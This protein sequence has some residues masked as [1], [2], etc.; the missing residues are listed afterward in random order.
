MKNYKL[1]VS[2][3]IFLSLLVSC[4]HGVVITV[5]VVDSQNKGFQCVKQD[6]KDGYFLPFEKGSD[7]LCASPSDTEDFMKAC[8]QHNVINITLCSING[9]S[10]L[11]KGPGTMDM[12]YP[13]SQLAGDNFVCLNP[14]DRKRVIE[15]CTL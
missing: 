5:C 8:K 14:Q 15:R 6:Q 3:P 7:L 12:P 9:E 10:F 11:C 1:R 2:L 4:A 13:I